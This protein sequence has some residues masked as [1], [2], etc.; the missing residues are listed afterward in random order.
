VRKFLSDARK[1]SV[2]GAALTGFDD[3]DRFIPAAGRHR[4][5][6]DV[7]LA[8]VLTAPGAIGLKFAMGS[9]LERSL[10]YWSEE[11]GAVL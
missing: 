9:L 6:H 5:P 1:P 4:A 3:P 11:G 10:V 7:W 8:S 2:R